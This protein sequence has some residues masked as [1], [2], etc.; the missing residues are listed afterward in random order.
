VQV[1]LQNKENMFQKLKKK[2]VVSKKRKGLWGNQLA[3][4]EKRPRRS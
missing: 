2:N 3:Q 1:L 4:A